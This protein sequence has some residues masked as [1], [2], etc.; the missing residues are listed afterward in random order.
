MQKKDLMD[1]H[2][3]LALSGLP[4]ARG[5]GLHWVEKGKKNISPNPVLGSHFLHTKSLGL[6]G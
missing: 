2:D 4:S 5:G 1:V 3:P 6:N